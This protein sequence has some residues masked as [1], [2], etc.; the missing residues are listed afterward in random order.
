MFIIQKS[1][2]KDLKFFN[3]LMATINAIPSLII[4]KDPSFSQ[5]GY[6][7]HDGYIDFEQKGDEIV[8]KEMLL[9][10]N[11][12][13]IVGTGVVYRHTNEV[14][15]KLQIRTL[16]TF[17]SVLDMIP[18]VG[19][20]ILGEDKKIST[21]VNVTGSLDDPQIQTNV[22]TDTLMSPLNIIKRTLEL[23]LELFK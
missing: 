16:K 17:S 4:F 22:I 9:R 7:V 23:P 2:I 20:L 8:I 10:G 14:N 6:F 5:E 13:D 15:L 19:G 1:F 18:L 11:S 3:N 21:N 12:A